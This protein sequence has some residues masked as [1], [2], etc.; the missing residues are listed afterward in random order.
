MTQAN[1]TADL[2]PCRFNGADCEQCANPAMMRCEQYFAE[3]E[4]LRPDEY[5]IDTDVPFP[6]TEWD[7]ED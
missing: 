5:D 4:S 1:T 3:R 6:F 2:S 7:Y